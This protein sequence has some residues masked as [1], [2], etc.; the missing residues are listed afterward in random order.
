MVKRAGHY[1]CCH[2]MY[3][4]HDQNALNYD[5]NW[6]YMDHNTLQYGLLRNFVIVLY[7]HSLGVATVRHDTIRQC[8]FNMQ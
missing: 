7:C 3:L 1:D 8:V 5:R 2:V 6:Q 4:T